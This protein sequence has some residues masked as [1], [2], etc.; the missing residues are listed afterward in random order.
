MTL[1]CSVSSAA[2]ATTNVVMGYINNVNYYLDLDNA[3]AAD[4]KV[5]TDFLTVIGKHVNVDI[6]DYPEEGQLEAAIIIPGAADLEEI[7]TE[8]TLLTA[9]KKTK[10]DNFVA[11]IK[12]LVNTENV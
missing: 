2:P 12:S 5:V 7:T 3:S 6:L 9:A 1:Y 11:L 8:Y 10:V 4:K